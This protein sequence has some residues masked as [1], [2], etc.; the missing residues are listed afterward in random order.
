VSAASTS[1]E[2]ASAAPV[3]RVLTWNLFHGRSLPPARGSLGAQFA[4]MLAGWEWDVALLQE[5]P[6]WWPG[7]LARAAGAEQ[8]SV[9]TSRN[10]LLPLRRALAERHPELL[11]SNGGGANAI[12]ARGEIVEHRALRLR[13]LPERRVGQ[14][15][16]LAGGG[17][18][19]NLH[20]S[21]N[22]ERAEDE[23]ERLWG[24]ALRFAD[25]APLILGGD[26]NLRAP[27]ARGIGTVHIAARDVDH[28]FATGARRLGDPHRLDR[29]VQLPAG[30]VELSDHVPLLAAV[31]TI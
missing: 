14:L 7:E 8:R 27:R 3:V 6:P 12:L 29:R 26:L 31:Q 16:R 4:R 24:A 21:T 23:L 13:Y 10:A 28:L 30:P 9:L 19:A 1:G 25:G 15:V 20:A 17:C 18:F 11:G 2:G 5:V 22:V